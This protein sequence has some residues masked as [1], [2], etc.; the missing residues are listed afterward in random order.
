MLSIKDDSMTASV[1]RQAA[2]VLEL[3]RRP[4][5][6]SSLFNKPSTVKNMYETIRNAERFDE[7]KMFKISTK[8]KSK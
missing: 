1:L 7:R 8:E 2:F 6:G 5:I 3:C 4:F